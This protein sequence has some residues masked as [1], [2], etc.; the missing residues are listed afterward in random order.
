MNKW[1]HWRQQRIDHTP[2]RLTSY[3]HHI[4]GIVLNMWIWGEHSVHY[5]Y[6]RQEICIWPKY[7]V[8][9]SV[10]RAFMAICSVSAHVHIYF[11]PRGLYVYWKATHHIPWTHMKVK[12][13][14]KCPRF[15]LL[16][17]LFW[18]DNVSQRLYLGLQ[19]CIA[20]FFLV[21][22]LRKII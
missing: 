20:D 16:L 12:N 18:L 5:I 19:P 3:Y 13:E 9:Y 17:L 14:H 11:R 4:G 15:C 7:H 10:T 8:V 21:S 2:M 1:S 6:V 22:L